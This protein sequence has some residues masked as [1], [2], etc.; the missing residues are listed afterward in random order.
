VVAE[1]GEGSKEGIGAAAKKQRKSAKKTKFGN[2]N[3]GK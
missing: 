2:S 1:A 3:N